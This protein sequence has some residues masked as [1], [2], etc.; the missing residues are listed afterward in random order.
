MRLISLDVLEPGMVLAKTIWNEAG[1]TITSKRC[2]CIT[3]D[4]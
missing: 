2:Y 1:Q 4:Y 3:S